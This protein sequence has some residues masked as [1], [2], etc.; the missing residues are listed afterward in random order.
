MLIQAE[1]QTRRSIHIC[2]R[3]PPSVPVGTRGF[4]PA[5]SFTVA[6]PVRSILLEGS[7]C[8]LGCCGGGIEFWDLQREE[9]QS[10]SNGIEV[11]IVP[12]KCLRISSLQHRLSVDRNRTLYYRRPYLLLPSIIAVRISPRNK[13]D[14]KL[15]DLWEYSAEDIVWDV[16]THMITYD[17]LPHQVSLRNIK[18]SPVGWNGSVLLALPNS[19]VFRIDCFWDIVGHTVEGVLLASGPEE[20]Q[21][22]SLAAID[23]YFLVTYTQGQRAWHK[24]PVSETVG[25]KTP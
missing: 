16:Y 20:C 17:D 12:R 1:L 15:L 13:D 5:S 2:I 22:G 6:D 24:Q 25:I 19:S 21:L 11:S 7:V 8:I 3:D 10:Q 9:R 18:I 23:G 14:N 4:T